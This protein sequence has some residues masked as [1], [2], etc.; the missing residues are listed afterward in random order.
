MPLSILD[1]ETLQVKRLITHIADADV[2][3]VWVAAIVSCSI[4]MYCS[5]LERTR[6]TITP[7]TFVLRLRFLLQLQKLLNMVRRTYHKHM[8]PPFSDYS[9]IHQHLA[10]VY[11]GEF[12]TISIVILPSGL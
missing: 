9:G 11:V 5:N 12:S 7:H 3:A 2:F 1:R 6:Y 8:S 4:H 10:H